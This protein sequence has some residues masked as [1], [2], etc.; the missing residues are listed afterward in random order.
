MWQSQALRSTGF[1]WILLWES[2]SRTGG[3]LIRKYRQDKTGNWKVVAICQTG[4]NWSRRTE[5]WLRWIAKGVV[6]EEK[7]EEGRNVACRTGEWCDLKNRSW[8]IKKMSDVKNSRGLPHP[9]GIVIILGNCDQYDR[10]LYF[11]V[12]IEMELE[13][14]QKSGREHLHRD[15][16]ALVWCKNFEDLRRSK[17]WSLV[18]KIHEDSTT[19]IERLQFSV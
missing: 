17:T 19:K 14:K 13:Q 16:K 10:F 5:L 4:K 12:V 3:Q 15:T 7:E 9:A 1:E 11:T 8:V 6:E 18:I 2:K